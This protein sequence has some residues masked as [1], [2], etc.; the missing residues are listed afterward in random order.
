M[1]SFELS[2]SWIPSGPSAYPRL[3]AV[4]PP[5]RNL[6]AAFEAGYERVGSAAP[7]RHGRLSRLF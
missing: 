5:Q 1:L 3:W 2:G 4:L 6:S 7:N